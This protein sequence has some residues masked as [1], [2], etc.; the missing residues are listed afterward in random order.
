MSKLI[1]ARF[2]YA[3]ADTASLSALP[4]TYPP[5]LEQ[6]QAGNIA[7]PAESY[8][9]VPVVSTGAAV[10]LYSIPIGATVIIA[11]DGNNTT[12]CGVAAAGGAVFAI[13]PQ[14]LVTVPGTLVTA[15][16]S[17]A[18]YTT[19]FATTSTAFAAQVLWAL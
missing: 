9:M 5:V 11:A 2:E 15:T 12:L 13:G 17:L 14:G 7:T 6:Y 18:A 8:G 19:A 10:T 1:E 16:L 3:C 4:P